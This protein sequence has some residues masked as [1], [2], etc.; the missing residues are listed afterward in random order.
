MQGLFIVMCLFS[1]LELG[2]HL[3]LLDF[4]FIFHSSSH[5]WIKS[6]FLQEELRH[7]S[8]VPSVNEMCSHLEFIMFCKCSITEF[9]HP[10]G[11]PKGKL[12]L[13]SN[14]DIV[15]GGK[16]STDRNANGR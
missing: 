12:D 5:C 7:I 9:L 3:H 13:L 1:V 15:E 14:W 6:L 11:S 4:C 2:C 8:Y 10:A 16:S